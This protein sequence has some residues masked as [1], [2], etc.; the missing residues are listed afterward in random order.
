MQAFST[1]FS[2]SSRWEWFQGWIFPVCVPSGR[3]FLPDDGWNRNHPQRAQLIPPVSIPVCP[4]RRSY[5]LGLDDIPTRSFEVLVV[6]SS[7]RDI[8]N[9]GDKRAVLELRTGL[10]GWHVRHGAY[11]ARSVASS[12]QCSSSRIF[13]RRMGIPFHPTS[14]IHPWSPRIYR[15]VC[16]EGL[17]S[18]S[19]DHSS[20]VKYVR[21]RGDIWTLRQIQKRCVVYVWSG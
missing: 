16:L 13:P 9:D 14:W 4:D 17:I 5:L 11:A 7:N 18:Q 20:S 10:C 21:G 1:I 19:G 6:N 12:G 2:Y 8:V 15:L 3:R